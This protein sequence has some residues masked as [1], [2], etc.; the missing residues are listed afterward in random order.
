MVLHDGW[1]GPPVVTYAYQQSVLKEEVGALQI[2]WFT[3]CRPQCINAYLRP[4]ASQRS[5]HRATAMFQQSA[6]VASCL[7]NLGGAQAVGRAMC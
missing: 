7:D 4:S 2:C 3:P 6:P 1:T 5:Q